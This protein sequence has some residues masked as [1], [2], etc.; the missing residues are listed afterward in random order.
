MSTVVNVL[1]KEEINALMK[2]FTFETAGLPPGMTART[3]VQGHS[4]SIYRSR[5]VMIQGKDAD[6]LAA[7]LIGAAPPK[8]RT[9]DIGTFPYDTFDCIGSD[10]AGSGDYF[11]PMTVCAAYVTKTN[12]LILK[13]LGVMDSKK[14]SD[15]KIC[16]LAEEIIP[17]IPHSLL[18]LDNIKYNERKSIGWSQVKMKAVLHNQAITNVLNKIEHPVDYI[19]IDQFAVQNVYENYALTSI[20]ERDKT[21]FE[22]KGESKAI[23]I[24]AA[25]IISR[26]AFVKWMDKIEEETG[27]SIYKG[28]GAK[29]DVQAAKIIARKSVDYLDTITKKDFKNRAK[30][31]A[32]LERKR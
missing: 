15:T 20:P 21:R 32:L 16:Q 7:E 19:V 3:K 30:A 5:K 22:T 1:T 27:L 9:E 23:A 26:Y 14:L 10:E 25:S 12:A 17:F 4:I 28:A 29:V 13:E 8:T 2:R 31:L 24:A 11:G 6:N 18:V